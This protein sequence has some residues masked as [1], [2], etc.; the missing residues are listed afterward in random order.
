VDVL[1]DAGT[2]E[3][4]LAREL[5]FGDT[6]PK[7]DRPG[8]LVPRHDVFHGERG[9]DVER[10][11]AVVAFTVA[12][13]AGN[14]DIVRGG[15]RLLIRLRNAVDVRAE[16]DDRRSLAPSGHPGGGYAGDAAFDGE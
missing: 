8:N 15:G 5:F 16:R 3:K 9:D 14:H 2:D 1:E 4:G 6:G 12:G 13:G 11:T 7:H 10:H